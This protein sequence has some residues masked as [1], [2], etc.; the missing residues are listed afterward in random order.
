MQAARDYLRAHLARSLSSAAPEARLAAA[1]TVACGRA[2]AGHGSIAAY[3]A[4]T[5]TVRIHVTGPAWLQHMTDLR[6]SLA[7]D[8]ARIAGLPV[9]DLHFELN[10]KP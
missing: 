7:R 8:L 9:A 3:D 6:S 5:A 1:W 4:A 2:M 10:K